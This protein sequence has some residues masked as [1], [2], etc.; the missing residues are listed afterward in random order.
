MVKLFEN[1]VIVSHICDIRRSNSNLFHQG[2]FAIER[3]RTALE[4]RKSREENLTRLGNYFKL[5][6]FVF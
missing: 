5:R 2:I 6:K 3:M 4:L 1:R